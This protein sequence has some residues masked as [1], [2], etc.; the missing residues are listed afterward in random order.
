MIVVVFSSSIQNRL[1][2]RSVTSLQNMKP[3]LK[4]MSIATALVRPKITEVTFAFPWSTVTIS[5]VFDTN[6]HGGVQNVAMNAKIEW[7]KN[8]DMCIASN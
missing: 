2:F 6:K 7:R 3:R 4:W 5:V 1:M 8:E